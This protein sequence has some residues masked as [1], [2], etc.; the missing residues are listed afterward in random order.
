MDNCDFGVLGDVWLYCL[1][2]SFRCLNNTTGISIILFH[3]QIFSQHL[4]NVIKT[5]LLNRPSMSNKQSFI[6]QL[7]LWCFRGCLV[8]LFKQQFSLFKQHNRYF[9]NTFYLL[10]FS[11]H[12]NNVIKTT[13]LSRPSMSNK[14][15][16][17]G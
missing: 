1:N 8:V 16:F 11:Q 12:L 3:P 9:H 15:S 4:N 5:T 17:R 10:I 14:Q 6:G 13:L 2:N 7:W